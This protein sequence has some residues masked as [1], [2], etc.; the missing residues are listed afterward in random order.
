MLTL[1]H[2]T[3]F[4]IPSKSNRAE[5]DSITFETWKNRTARLFS[6]LFGG[7]TSYQAVGHWAG[8]SGLVSEDV[9]ILESF[10]SEE[11]FTISR[12]TVIKW[13]E[14]LRGL[15]AQESIAVQFDNVLTLVE[16]E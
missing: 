12:E 10:G 9:T 6:R 8:E 3:R 7:C 5:I 2:S 1:N 11:A 13:A 15:L 16:E 4:Y 14:N